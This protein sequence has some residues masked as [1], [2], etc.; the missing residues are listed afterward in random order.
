MPPRAMWTGQLRL[1]LVS[2]GVRMYAA[3]ESANRVSMNQLHKGCHQ[4]V[5]QQLVCPAHGPVNREDIAR[6]YEYV[7]L[8]DHSSG[9]GIANGLS[10]ERLLEQIRL[11]RSLQQ[12]YP[13]TIF[14]GSEVDIRADGTLDYPDDLLAQL[15]LVVASVH[16]AMGQDS[17]TMTQRIIRAMQHPAVTIIGHP[18][19]RLLSRREPVQ[20]D[21]EALLQAARETGTETQESRLRTGH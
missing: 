14:C 12:R 19:T 3:T 2:F 21:L 6:G 20:F 15:D 8:T 17:Q 13:I 18:S 11:L 4:R 5:R 10:N 1:S 7:A 9:R 16:S